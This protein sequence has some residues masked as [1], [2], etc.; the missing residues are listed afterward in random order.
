MFHLHLPKRIHKDKRGCGIEEKMRQAGLDPRKE[1]VFAAT[2][3]AL[4]LGVGTFLY[5]KEGQIIPFLGFAL[6]AFIAVYFLLG[7]A[8]RL[9][10]AQQTALVDEF[11]RIFG[12][13][14][15]YLRDGIPVYHALEEVE[16][17]A[18]PRMEEKIR[19]LL[20]EIDA[21]KSVAPFVRFAE[22]FPSLEIR[23]VMLSVYKMVDQGGND[24]YFKQYSLLFSSLRK[25]KES[26]WEKREDDKLNSACI[27]PLLDSAVTMMLVTVG[28]V[29]VIGGVIDGI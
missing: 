20:S 13:F 7:R 18:S 5:W 12:Y 24:A 15:I 10:K 23:Q 16:R 22:G 29:V 1:Y 6:L 14:S 26:E 28:I 19:A 21:D 3:G 17:F 8:S 27:L 2:S 4:L 25:S 9:L 11:V